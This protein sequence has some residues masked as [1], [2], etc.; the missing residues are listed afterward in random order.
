MEFDGHDFVILGVVLGMG[1]ALLFA[2]AYLIPSFPVESAQTFFNANPFVVRSGITTR[3][4]AIAGAVWLVGASISTLWGIVR[5]V[6]AGQEGY[7]VSSGFDLLVLLAAVLVAGRITIAITDRTSR[8]EYLPI[9]VQMQE[10]LFARAAFIIRHEG[11]NPEESAKGIVVPQHEAE[12]RMKAQSAHLDQ[13]GKLL[14][15][16]RRKGEDNVSYVRRLS[17]YFPEAKID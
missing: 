13:V 15:E 10:E 1:S 14:D 5:T 7:L 2:K 12:A 9:V 4:E 11:V 8:A 17:L 16:P 6:R 3:H